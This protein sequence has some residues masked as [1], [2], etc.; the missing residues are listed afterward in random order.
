MTSLT[1]TIALVQINLGQR[2]HTFAHTHRII[3]KK[4]TQTL[5]TDLLENTPSNLPKKHN[6]SHPKFLKA[7]HC[8]VNLALRTFFPNMLEYNMA[9]KHLAWQ[10]KWHHMLKG[11]SITLKCYVATITSLEMLLWLLEVVQIDPCHRKALPKVW[12]G[13]LRVHFKRG[14]FQI[15]VKVR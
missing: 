11:V 7:T 3:E 10:W 13:G 5:S 8:F 12:Q 15:E 4:H 1:T 2:S 9:K 14:F 6:R